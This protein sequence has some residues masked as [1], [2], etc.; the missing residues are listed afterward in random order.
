MFKR[1]IEGLSDTDSV[2][3]FTWN[4]RPFTGCKGDTVAAAL[5]GAGIRA[6][7]SH[8]V[9]GE[10]RAAF[11]MMGTCFECLVEIDGRPNCQACQTRLLEGMSIRSQRGERE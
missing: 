10:D 11:C 2:V 7:R 9:T 8:P 4:G 1:K 5:L 6:S 3:G